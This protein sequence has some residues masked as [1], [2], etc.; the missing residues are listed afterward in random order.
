MVPAGNNNNFAELKAASLSGYAY[1]D[2]N[3]NGTFDSGETPLAGVNLTLTGTDDLGNPVNL[4]TTTAP[5]NP[6]LFAGLRPGAY[7]LTETPP[8]GYVAGTISQSEWATF[9]HIV[10]GQTPTAGVLPGFALTS[11]MAVSDV[12]FANLLSTQ[13]VQTVDLTNDFNLTGITANGAKFSGG[14][15][16]VGNA[17]SANLL[18]TS[19]IYGGVNFNIGAAGENNVIQA[20]GQTIAL[21]AGQY[22]K[23]EFLATAVQGNQKSQTFTVNYSDGTSTTLTQ[24]ISDWFTPQNFAGETVVAKT[25]HRNMAGGGAD[26]RSFD[27]YGY[28]INVDSTKTVSSITLPNNKNV[29]VLAIS[30][31]ATVAPPTNVTTLTMFALVVAQFGGG[32]GG[33]GL[34]WTPPVG[35]IT[36]YNVYR[37]TTAGGEST[38]PLNSAPLSPT[39]ASYLDSTVVPGNTYY[40]VVQAINGPAT[41]ASSNEA[42]GEIAGNSG[43]VAVDLSAAFNVN[44]ISTDGTKVSGGGLDTLGNTLSANLLGTSQTWNGVSFAIGAAGSNNVV[45]ASGQTTALPQGQYAQLDLLATAV[46][47]SQLSQKFIV[48]YTDGTSTTVTQS[49][50]DWHAPQ[51]YAGESVAV[52]STYRNTASGGRDSRTFDVYGYT[53]PLDSSKTVSSITLPNDKHIE[54]LAISAVSAVAAPTGLTATAVSA[55]EIDLSWAAPTGN[56][57]GYNVY[58]GTASGGESTTPLNSTPLPAGA[59]SFQDTSVTPG[60][61]YYYV[62][63]AVSGPVLS[64]ISTEATA[65]APSS[66]TTTL[67]SI[68]PA[69]MNKVGITTNGAKFSGG[70]DGVGNALSSTLLGNSQAWNGANFTIGAAGSNNVVQAAGQ[71]IALPAGQYSK[72]ELLATSVNG[73]QAGQV[74]VIHYTDGTSTSITQSMSDWFT[75]QSYSGESLAVTSVYRN[76]SAGGADNRTFYVYGYVLNTDS[77]KTISSITLPTNQH[78]DV[79]AI[80]TVE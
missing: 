59:T 78:V 58:R 20:T 15:D 56:V 61:T 47:G 42:S 4:S 29:D 1:V 79:L 25:T 64:A 8:A 24:S 72:V 49:I 50:S 77:S 74:F 21:P 16:G 5:G 17:L 13:V 23:I 54:V 46:N 33:I 12:D 7:T 52:T 75:P 37:G 66:G 31:V 10:V 18:G 80:D 67:K 36:G 68:C 43:N 3:D 76:T 14:L 53:L 63:R 51:S 60:N 34:T 69:A 27:V 19:Q 9:D 48:N 38:T 26:N 57:T 11:G 65:A 55:G 41:S 40:Y 45:Q 30:T 39:A 62:I 70:L 28:T 6:Y 22:T 44:G 32:T 73:N 2:A 35:S 71:T